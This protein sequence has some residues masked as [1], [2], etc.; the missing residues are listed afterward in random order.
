MNT[1]SN[2]VITALLGLAIFSESLPP[3]WWIG[4]SLLVA[5]NVIVGRKDEGKQDESVL[6]EALS[7][8]ESGTGGYEQL[9]SE[10]GPVPEEK[11][12]Q[13]DEEDVLDLGNIEDI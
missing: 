1:S 2:F 12:E 11:D 4:A 6:D 3:M 9:P 7:E 13:E 8:A 10:A 5:G